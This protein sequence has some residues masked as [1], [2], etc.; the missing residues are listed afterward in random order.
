MPNLRE[1]LGDVLLQVVF[2]SQLAEEAGH[3]TRQDVL[4]AVAEKMI[5]RHPRVFNPEMNCMYTMPPMF[6][7]SSSVYDIVDVISPRLI[8]MKNQMGRYRLR[9]HRC[10]SC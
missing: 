7:T 10:R 3:F 5:R 9:W 2:P 1:E 6:F 4:N 8:S